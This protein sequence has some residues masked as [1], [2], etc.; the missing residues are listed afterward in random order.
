MGGVL[1]DLTCHMNSLPSSV[2]PTFWLLPHA[3]PTTQAS[4]GEGRTRGAVVPPPHMYTCGRG[5]NLMLPV[6][7]GG[8]SN[9]DFGKE[10]KFVMLTSPQTVEYS[11][12]KNDLCL[13]PFLSPEHMEE[14]LDS[15]PESRFLPS[16]LEYGLYGESLVH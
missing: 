4:E 12:S 16:G 6:D 14:S 15:V 5:T 13:N 1:S 3:T 9:N 7:W 10:E 8:E 2:T 11:S